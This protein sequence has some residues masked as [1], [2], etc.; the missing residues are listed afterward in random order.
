MA[1]KRQA[2]IG[3][4]AK[5]TFKKVKISMG[6]TRTLNAQPIQR[7]ERTMALKRKA[8]V[9]AATK[10]KSKKIKV[11]TTQALSKQSTQQHENVAI[12][13]RLKNS[14][15]LAHVL[16][17]SFDEMS[18]DTSVA[19]RATQP[20]IT[21]KKTLLSHLKEDIPCELRLMIFRESA[22]SS[23]ILQALDNGFD[24]A[25]HA[26]FLNESKKIHAEINKHNVNDFNKRPIKDLLNIRH[27]SVS[28]PL[29]FRAQKI[30][31]M[32]NINSL[33][34]DGMKFRQIGDN[35]YDNGSEREGELGLG[36][37]AT[38]ILYWIKGSNMNCL[39][40]LVVK[41]TRAGL[42]KKFSDVLGF[43]PREE[44]Q[45]DG[46][47]HL[48]WEKDNGG[49]VLGTLRRRYECEVVDGD[50]WWTLDWMIGLRPRR[51]VQT[52]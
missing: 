29:E 34:F 1:P 30:M 9:E 10:I 5:I 22:N 36:T 27:L 51:Y 37:S 25:L 24:P 50:G 7:Q 43:Q 28:F 33:F 19:A 16:K 39:R 4:I 41:V 46:S 17:Q 18:R 42:G 8:A 6:P 47:V 49:L 52:V 12:V 38:S 26:E 21:K 13:H 31:L 14:G 20:T 44:Y 11:S 2:A 3:A 23:L 40:K 48:V 45:P 32:N 15:N 35:I